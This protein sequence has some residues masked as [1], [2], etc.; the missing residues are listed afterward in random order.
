MKSILFLLTLFVSTALFG[1]SGR[2]NFSAEYSPNFSNVTGPVYIYTGYFKNQGFRLAHNAFLKSGFR[3]NKNLDI[4]AGL[5]YLN[6]REYD[7]LLLDGQLDIENIES[8]RTHHYL[9]VPVGLRYRIG[10]FYVHPEMGIAINFDN[11]TQQTSYLTNGISVRQRHQDDFNNRYNNKITLP[12]YFTVGHE[13]D[14]GYCSMLL[15]LKGYY[16]LN[17]IA[18]IGLQARHYYGV[19][20]VTGLK[21]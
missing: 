2:F 3:L 10:S 7:L 15:G 19:G 12:V 8:V 1:Q 5:G 16:S 13:F 11:T 18:D 4:T 9:S 21:F 6:A 20:I 14:L 17:K